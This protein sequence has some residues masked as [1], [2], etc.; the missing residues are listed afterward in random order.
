VKPKEIV[1]KFDLYLASKG[2]EFEAVV[3]GGAALALLGVITRETQDCDVLDPKI[4]S[5]IETA[6]IEFSLEIS[7]SGH[8]IK[9]NWLNNGPESLKK[10]LPK[11]WRL[12][13]EKLYLGKAL[14]LHTLG[15]SDLLKSK[16]FAYCDRGQD[17]KDCI[18]MTPSQA[19]LYGALD[20]VKSQD[21]N[22]GWPHHVEMQ[23]AKL[24]K[25]LGYGT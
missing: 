9:A 6:A 1:A 17:L 5:S 4:P 2:L 12:R 7:K 13:L 25:K 19:D 24:A 15:R 10:A 22:P 23:I 18:E 16:L 20:W 3:I 21:A 14:T 8:E 11:H